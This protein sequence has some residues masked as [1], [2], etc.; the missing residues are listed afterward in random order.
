MVK[1]D[2]ISRF[3]PKNF[4]PYKI[5]S[6][7]NADRLDRRLNLIPAAQARPGKKVRFEES[8]SHRVPKPGRIATGLFQDMQKGSLVR[9]KFGAIP[10]Y[11]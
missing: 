1:G 2:L 6:S 7:A 10:K 8:S 3:F 9:D 11:P 5:F 4:H